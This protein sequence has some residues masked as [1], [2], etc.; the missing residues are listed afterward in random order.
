MKR[1]TVYIGIGLFLLPLFAAGGFILTVR[2][3]ALFR[4]D[5]SYFT[6]HYQELYPSPGTVA[7]AIEQALHDDTPSLF[8]ELTGLRLKIRPPQAN[9]DVRLMILW[10]VTDKGYFQYLFFNTRTY[11]RIIYNIKQVDG[12]WVWVPRDLY[13]FLDSGDWLLFFSPAAA[14]WWIVLTVTAVGLGIFSIAA[15][16]R[17]QQYRFPKS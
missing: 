1:R 6:P 15:R 17:E 5:P 16:F 12:R 8:A 11:H 10:K 13:Y 3:L 4:Y 7:S 14:I 9:P 2:A